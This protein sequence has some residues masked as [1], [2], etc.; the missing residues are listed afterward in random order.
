VQRLEAFEARLDLGEGRLGLA[1]EAGGLVQQLADAPQQGV[2]LE[3]IAR[4][5]LVCASG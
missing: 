5:R 4:L 3:R 1:D 2:V